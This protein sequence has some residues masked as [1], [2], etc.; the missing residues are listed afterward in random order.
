MVGLTAFLQHTVDFTE[1]VHPCTFTPTQYRYL[2][3]SRT[4][5]TLS[6]TILILIFKF[7]TNKNIQLLKRYCGGDM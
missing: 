5:L 2:K 4:F 7:S 3:L 1:Q 6:K